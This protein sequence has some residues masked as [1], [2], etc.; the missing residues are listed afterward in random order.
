MQDVLG[1]EDIWS[2]LSSEGFS[3]P[4]DEIDSAKRLVDLVSNFEV[5]SNPIYASRDVDLE[6]LKSS[7]EKLL[8]ISSFV[9][10]LQ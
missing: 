9:E 6:F 7:L 5:P 2:V 1:V 4:S 10:Q 8:M 3:V